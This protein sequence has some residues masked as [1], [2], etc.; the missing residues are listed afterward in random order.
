[1]HRHP[2]WIVPEWPAPDNVAGLITTR[3]GGFSLPPF[4]SLN[5]ALH[6]GDD[7]HAVARNRARVRQ[8]LPAEPCWLQQVHGVRV[9]HLGANARGGEADAA[10]TRTRA[11]VCTVMVADCLPLLLCDRAGTVVACAHAGWRGLSAGVVEATLHAMDCAT[12]QVLAYLGPAIGAHAFE[13]GGDVRQAFAA[14]HAQDTDCFR[15]KAPG[16]DAQP[17][18]WADLAELVRRR[19][20]RAGVQYIHGGDCCTFHDRTRFYSHRR[21]GRT[22]RHAAFIWLN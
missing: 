1:M 3:A 2:D 7:P 15:D 12:D 22:G 11:T 5:L 8:A 18:W 10:V 21:D 16:R 14:A 4:D 9:A 19:L 13:V 20:Q 17:R 6:V